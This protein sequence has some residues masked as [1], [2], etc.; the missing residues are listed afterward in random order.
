[1]IVEICLS[2]FGRGAVMR[3]AR[4]EVKALL[5]AGKDVTVITDL[6]HKRYLNFFK[7][8]ENKPKIIP[9]KLVYLYGPTRKVIGELSFAIKCY[10]A[11]KAIIEKEKIDLIICHA[12]SNC[13]AAGYFTKRRKIPTAFVI[14]ELINERIKTSTNPYN[15]YVTKWYQLAIQFAIS[16]IE[17]FIADSSYMKKFVIKEGALYRKTYILHN[18]VDLSIFSPKQGVQKEFDILF[19]GRL[20]IEKGVEVLIKASKFISKNRK[21]L[22]IGD[23]PLFKKLEIMACNT[24]KNIKFQGW[25]DHEELPKFIRKSKILV[26]PSLSEPQG[27]VVLEA[28]A[29]GVPVIGTYVGGIPDMI[30]HNKNGFLIKP[31]D[32]RVLGETI[33]NLL[34]DE[35][36]LHSFSQETLKTAQKFSLTKF[37]KDIIN[38]YEKLINSFT[39]NYL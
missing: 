29:C 3:R 10:Q 19:I 23:G 22:I 1:M 2:F 7:D 33:D 14:Q 24:S 25:V 26:V 13:F 36:K 6:L 39:L 18:P 9:I 34:K 12:V 20:S 27:V 37:N 28:I 35:K 31:N 32:S 16:K 4:N 17:F 38:L 8:L 21:I 30:V 11:L 15:W 5:K